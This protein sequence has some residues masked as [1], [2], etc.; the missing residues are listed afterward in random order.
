MFE[1][2]EHGQNE[3]AIFIPR[4]KTLYDV[5]TPAQINNVMPDNGGG[6]GGGT[7]SVINNYYLTANYPMQSELSVIQEL[8]LMEMAL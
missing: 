6:N 7:R 2:S 1:T 4:G 3:T 5:A 8:K